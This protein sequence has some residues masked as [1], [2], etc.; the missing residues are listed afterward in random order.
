LTNSPFRDII[1]IQR[2]R[3]EMIMMT[4]KE[5]LVKLSW[6]KFHL[7]NKTEWSSKDYK[8]YKEIEKI[9]V[10]LKKKIEEE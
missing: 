2:N 1:K 7:E 4:N 6:R 5:M 8:D 9:I 3:K 10:E